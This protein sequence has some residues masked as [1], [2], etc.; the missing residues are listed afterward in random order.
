MNG[1]LSAPEFYFAEIQ[2]P[3]LFFWKGTTFQFNFE[4][5]KEKLEN[6]E[7]SHQDFDFSDSI[8]LVINSFF[9]FTF[10]RF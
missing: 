9:C 6:F 2:P 4:I 7:E 8:I 10:F 5:K 1:F 3:L